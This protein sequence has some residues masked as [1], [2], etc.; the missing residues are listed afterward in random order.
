MFSSSNYVHNNDD[1]PS[2]W[3]L[4]NYMNLPEK[5]I[6]QRFKIKSIF[7]HAD[8][9]PSLIIS[10]FADKQKYYFKD[11]SADKSGDMIALVAGMLG[12][13]YS[14]AYNKIKKDYIE[15]KKSGGTPDK[16]L[17]IKSSKWIVKNIKTRNWNTRDAKFWSS[18]NISSKI[19]IEYN[20]RPILSYTMVKITGDGEILQSFDIYNRDYMYGYFKNDGILYKIYKPKDKKNKFMTFDTSYIQG[21][22]QAYYEDVMIIASSLKDIMTLRS[23]NIKADIIA[24]NSENTMIDSRVIKRIKSIHTHVLVLFDNDKAGIKAMQKYKDLYNLAICYIPYEK[25]ISDIMKARGVNE[26]KV[27]IIPFIHKSMDKYELLN[28][29]DHEELEIREQRNRELRGYA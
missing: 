1:I 4:D 18:F 27:I 7:N 11:F 6:G 12:L 16:P 5:A 26:S 22:E 25:D 9:D 28:Y 3:I 21:S 10:Y 24:P 23:M 13:N 2:E 14:N 8:K 20:V 29:I 17:S 15:F 19:L